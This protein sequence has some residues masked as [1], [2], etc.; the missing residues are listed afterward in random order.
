MLLEM[1][2]LA[3]RRAA[4]FVLDTAFFV[5]ETAFLVCLCVSPSCLNDRIL[6]YLL[7]RAESPCWIVSCEILPLLT[8][9]R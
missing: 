1:V 2:C 9:A 3:F 6:L 5:L 8:R 7:R 4:F